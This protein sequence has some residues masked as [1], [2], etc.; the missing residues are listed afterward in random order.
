MGASVDCHAKVQATLPGWLGGLSLALPSKLRAAAA[1]HAAEVSH[2]G[3]VVRLATELGR[4]TAGSAADAAAAAEAAETLR[5]AGVSVRQ[6][7]A[8]SFTAAARARYEGGPWAQ[9]VPAAAVFAFPHPA[10]PRAGAVPDSGSSAPSGGDPPPA[11][12][13]NRPREY[14][15]AVR[16]LDAL[17]ATELHSA[18]PEHR[19]TCMLSSGGDGA[20]SFWS[21][22]PSRPALRTANAQWAV[23][24]RTRLGLA[25][26]PQRGLACS[27]RNACDDDPC[28]TPLDDHLHHPSVCPKG[29]TGRLR[30]HNAVAATIRKHAERTGAFVD[31]ERHVPELYV[32]RDNGQVQERIMDVVVQYPASGVRFLLDVT[33]RSPFAAELSQPHARPGEAARG[34]EKDKYAHYGAAVAPFAV[35]SFGRFGVQ[36]QQVLAALHKESCEYGKLR[37]G[38][39]RPTALNLRAL[40]AD[41]EAVVV[42]HSAQHVLRA[43]GASSLQ[44]LGWAGARAARPAQ[45]GG[46]GGGG[47]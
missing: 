5:E 3:A 2:R 20:G 1:F 27:L 36:A 7:A 10:A 22:V 45:R 46:G 23:A 8:P 17:R 16:G 44:A 34:G 6:A 43:L 14:G 13:P 32:Q 31:S 18:M 28:G 9:D 41:I 26:P 11:G 30:C 15:R 42:Q 4:P 35:E 21:T 19:Q 47:G 38:T 39:G 24:T 12:A 33:V 25:T 29:R 37:P 40:R